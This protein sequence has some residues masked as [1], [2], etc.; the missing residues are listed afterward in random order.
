L[1][2]IPKVPRRAFVAREDTRLV[3]ANIAGILTYIGATAA[4]LGVVASGGTLLLAVAAA[5]AGG[6]TAGGIG[7]LI[8]RAIGRKIGA[9]G[10]W[11]VVDGL[12]A[13]TV[14]ELAVAADL[15]VLGQPD[16][17]RLLVE[18]NTPEDVIFG[19]GRPVL[20]VPHQGDFTN[21]GERALVAWNGSREATRAVQDAIP[22]RE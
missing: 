8:A 15:V 3:T 6:A 13:P 5:A 7:A 14:S 2:D 16:P 17:D 1:A 10:R 20:M 19:C 22:A 4:A 9:R 21:V 12:L 11:H 18:L